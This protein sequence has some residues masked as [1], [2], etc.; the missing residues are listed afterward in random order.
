MKSVYRQWRLVK[1][2]MKCYCIYHFDRIIVINNRDYNFNQNNRDYQFNH[3]CA[4]LSETEKEHLYSAFISVHS[5]QSTQEFC[6]L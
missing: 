3:Y 6:A 2:Q 1:G 4:A 5:G